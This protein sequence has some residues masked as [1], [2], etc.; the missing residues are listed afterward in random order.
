MDP[1]RPL[2]VEVKRGSLEDGPG[3][4]SVVFFK[5]CPLR[6]VFCH[7]PEAQQP[8]PEIALVTQRCIRCGSCAER[9]PLSAI[10]LLSSSR[11][12][13][14]QCDF[15]GQC[16]AEC[17]S[18]ALRLIG[19]YWSVEELA[20]WLLRDLP[21]YRESGG[22][23]TLSGGECTLFPDYVHRLGASLRAEEVHIAIETCGFFDYG[24]FSEKILPHVDLVLFDLKLIDAQASLR[25]LGQPNERMLSNLKRLLTER[26]VRVL[27]RIPLIPGITD[28]RQNLA[29]I[30]DQLYEAGATEVALLA[31]NPLAAGMYEALGRAAPGTQP[32]FMKAER[33]LEIVEMFRETI[34]CRTTDYPARQSSCDRDFI[35]H[36]LQD[37]VHR[38]G[39]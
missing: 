34:R 16:A 12:D 17:P 28:T 9:C 29:G 19:K 23:V 15:C 37:R 21:F 18:G 8:G 30:V 10:D 22:G 35:Q 31:Y 4:R 6:C 5:G 32:G 13:R 1:S 2:I 11:I 39:M 25:Y 36:D 26:G 38:N 14:G 33:E 3:I 20:E 27:P 24:V 7:N